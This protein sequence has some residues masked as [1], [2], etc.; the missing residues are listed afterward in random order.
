MGH[1]YDKRKG[2]IGRQKICNKLKF[3]DDFSLNWI[4]IDFS[5]NELRRTLKKAIFSYLNNNGNSMRT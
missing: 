2:K 5:T 3:M 4:G 1:F